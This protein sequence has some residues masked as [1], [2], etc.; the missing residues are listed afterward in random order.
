M[1]V[2]R[3]DILV[4]QTGAFEVIIS[5]ADSTGGIGSRAGVPV[6]GVTAAIVG[7]ARTSV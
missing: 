6:G 4:E 3:D 2:L 7:D 1:A 5:I